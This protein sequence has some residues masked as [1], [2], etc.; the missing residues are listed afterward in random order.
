[1]PHDSDALPTPTYCPYCGY[2]VDHASG[3]LNEDENARAVPRSV[4]LCMKCG[5]MSLF[6]DN[7]MLRR[8]TM[9]EFIELTSVLG[10]QIAMFREAREQMESELGPIVPKPGR[11]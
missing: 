5:E 6:D 8:P 10:P 4:N 9:R 1:M 2:L 11:N 7:M 3:S